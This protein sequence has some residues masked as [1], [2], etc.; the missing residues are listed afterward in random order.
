VARF[1]R[2]VL[3]LW[4]H[5]PAEAASPLHLEA[6]W[7]DGAK[8]G[9]T[10]TLRLRLRHTLAAALT[11]DVTVP[12]PPGVTL[13]EPVNGVRQVQGVLSIRRGVDASDAPTVI[14]LPLRFALGG[15]F[16]VPEARA[17]VAFEEMPRAV[18]P[19]RPLRVE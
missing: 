8:A 9:K 12:L 5:P 6:L 17:R 2:P 4:S 19:A 14:E 18:A 16:V 13:A 15:R 10:G 1:E 7:P 11:A 3:R